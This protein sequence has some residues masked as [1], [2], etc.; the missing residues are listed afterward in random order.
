MDR[1]EVA[2]ME[3]HQDTEI[4]VSESAHTICVAAGGITSVVAINAELPA[5][6]DEYAVLINKV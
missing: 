5:G 1:K 3:N 6:S 2:R 4:R